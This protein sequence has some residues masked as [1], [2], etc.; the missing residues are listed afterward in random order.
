MNP[1]TMT[2]TGM[3]DLTV[4]RR[5]NATP[6]AVYDAHVDVEKLKKWMLG[7]EGWT[8]PHCALDPKVGGAFSYT[9]EDSNSGE[10][11]TI[12]GHFVALDRPNRIEHVEVMDMP[13]MT[14]PES[15]V[16]TEFAPDGG[17]TLM[18]MTIHYDSVESREGAIA[19][20]MEEGMAWSYDNLERIV[21]T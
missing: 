18:T 16:V 12:R 9:W 21:S 14:S 17:G 20:G 7:P 1:M 3:S 6:E 11:F 8:M 13:G 5:F 19:S 4:K 10:Q 15:Q 2:K